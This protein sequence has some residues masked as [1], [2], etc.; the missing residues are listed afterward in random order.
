MR[1]R[2]TIFILVVMFCC[3]GQSYTIAQEK[4]II[5][6]DDQYNFSVMTL[7]EMTMYQDTLPLDAGVQYTF[8][9]GSYITEQDT[10]YFRIDVWEN[11]L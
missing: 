1:E 3:V 6:E 11:P 2:F 10:I 4:Y 5:L 7:A 8:Y 9:Q